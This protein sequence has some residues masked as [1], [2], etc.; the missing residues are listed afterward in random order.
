MTSRKSKQER[1]KQSKVLR[2]KQLARV[3]PLDETAE[4][5][6]GGVAADPSALSHN[7]TYSPLPRFYVDRVVVCRRCKK[8]EVW[9]AERQKWWY[10]VAKGNIFSQAVLCRECRPAA[11]NSKAQARRVHLEGVARKRK[12]E[13]I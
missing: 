6:A 10:E 5:P 8:E 12:N 7:N 9:T 4:M 1:L 3:D 2:A 11:R 13:K